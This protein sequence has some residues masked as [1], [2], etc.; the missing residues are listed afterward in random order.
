MLLWN[1]KWS[2]ILFSHLFLRKNTEMKIRDCWDQYV[3]SI[4]CGSQGLKEK[5]KVVLCKHWFPVLIFN[6]FLWIFCF[7]WDQLKEIFQLTRKFLT[8]QKW[9]CSFIV[10]LELVMGG[11][12]WIQGMGANLFWID[13]HIFQKGRHLWLLRNSSCALC[14]LL[15]FTSDW[16]YL[17]WPFVYFGC[18]SCANISR[19][20]YSEAL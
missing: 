15:M 12:W 4:T 17:R 8:W 19:L 16:W 3:R 18:S 9:G 10:C 6:L 20:E 5:C 13:V 11:A 2:A 14:K 7:F 1:S